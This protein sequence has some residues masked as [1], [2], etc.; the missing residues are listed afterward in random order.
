M[1]SAQFRSAV[2]TLFGFADPVLFTEQAASRPMTAPSVGRV[3]HR[4]TCHTLQSAR[5]GTRS[6]QGSASVASPGT[7][8]PCPTVANCHRV[9]RAASRGWAGSGLSSS[10][11]QMR[12]RR[13]SK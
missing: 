12:P 9:Q 10:S 7:R 2:A 1:C 5:S 4:L 3:A 8:L 11:S 6:E 13:G